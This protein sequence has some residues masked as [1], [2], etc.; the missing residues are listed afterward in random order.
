MV[1]Q[2]NRPGQGPGKAKRSLCRKDS[3]GS[4]SEIPAGKDEGLYSNNIYAHLYCNTLSSDLFMFLCDVI[5]VLAVGWTETLPDTPV[6]EAPPGPEVPEKIKKRYRK[7]KT[8]LEE[9]FPTYLQVCH[10]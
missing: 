9:A 4:M 2:R 10:L 3:S 8:K 7:K 5:F 1:R 6:D